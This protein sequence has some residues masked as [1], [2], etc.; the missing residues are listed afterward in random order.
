MVLISYCLQNIL[1]MEVSMSMFIGTLE[2]WLEAADA[3]DNYRV[4]ATDPAFLIHVLDT[5]TFTTPDPGLP[6]PDPR[7]LGIHATCYL[8]TESID[9]FGG[10]ADPPQKAPELAQV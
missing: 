6:L 10:L 1:I 8:D 7:Y 4:C 5:V 2:I 9:E 3:P